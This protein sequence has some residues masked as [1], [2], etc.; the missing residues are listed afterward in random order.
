VALA[1]TLGGSS[2]RGDVGLAADWVVNGP[3]DLVSDHG[4]AVVGSLLDQA[5]GRDLRRLDA[6]TSR[7][8]V[9]GSAGAIRAALLRS[10][11]DSALAGARPQA[12]RLPVLATT[13]PV[14]F[15]Q[16]GARTGPVLKQERTAGADLVFRTL[17]SA[18]DESVDALLRVAWRH[19]LTLPAAF[20]DRAAAFVSWWI[21]RPELSYEP[22]CWPDT[23]MMIGLLRRELS[24]QLAYPGRREDT[25][26]AVRRTW[27][28]LLLDTATDMSQLLDTVVMVGAMDFA[29][30][31][32]CQALIRK[33]MTRAV[34]EPNPSS[35]I[36]RACE[37]LWCNRH[38]ETSEALT[39]LGL[40]PARVPVPPMLTDVIARALRAGWVDGDTAGA[41]DAA[42]ILR[43]RRADVPREWR[44]RHEDDLLL[45]DLC[46]RVAE[47]AD[48]E[49]KVLKA[50]HALDMTVVAA[51]AQQVAAALSRAAD[52]DIVG[53]VLTD[54]PGE[55]GRA[56]LGVFARNYGIRPAETIREEFLM[57]RAKRLASPFRSRLEGELRRQL[58][59]GGEPLADSATRLLARDGKAV[60]SDWDEWLRAPSRPAKRLRNQ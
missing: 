15:V 36:A 17:C 32:V 59:Q 22:G 43:E 21:G 47:S 42:R 2:R 40:V 48:P 20:A 29:D 34:S 31:A 18:P 33:V 14:G 60:R 11:I 19:R 38:P 25:V 12:E 7:G 5:S 39:T 26:D 6:S 52:Q 37:V 46:A 13:A 1:V 49:R 50:L 4:E 55:V 56:L 10:E 16:V 24:R 53:A 57:L 35:A 30:P 9:P 28:R 8:R 45:A 44:D 58:A 23:D 51:R 54:L 41:L 27:W 3:P